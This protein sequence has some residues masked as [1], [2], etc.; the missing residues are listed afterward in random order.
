MAVYVDDQPVELAGDSLGSVLSAATNHLA[1]S[2]RIVVEVLVDG[3]NLVG[4]ELVS[5]QSAG[6]EQAEVRLYSADPRVLG[7]ETLDQVR[8]LLGEARQAQ[9]EAAELIM[10]DRQADAM[11]RVVAAVD[12]WRQAQDAIL[13]TTRLVGINL[14]EQQ[15][16]GEPLSQK[17]KSLLDQIKE[18]KSLIEGRDFVAL[19][20]SLQYE[21]PETVKVWENM[22]DQLSGLIGTPK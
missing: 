17:I 14:D 2:G 21:W 15:F 10:Q 7:G 4:D 3:Q 22:V 5:R 20:D 9:Q 12:G 11:Q 8:R 13:N 18:L 1:S 6:V 19:A 16:S